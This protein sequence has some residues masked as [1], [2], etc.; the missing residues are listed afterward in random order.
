VGSLL[1]SSSK[2]CAVHAR[3]KPEA[4]EAGARNTMEKD[5]YLKVR[6]FFHFCFHVSSRVFDRLI[7]QKIFILVMSQY[8]PPVC[9]KNRARG[10]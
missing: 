8:Y 10:V 7:L 4:T 1:R 2:P 5:L 6:Q 9:K 3:Q